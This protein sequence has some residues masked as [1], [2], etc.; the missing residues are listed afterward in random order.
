MFPDQRG[1]ITG[2]A[3]RPGFGAGALI[4]APIATRLD[5]E[6]R[7][8]QTFAILGVAYFVAV[9]GGALSWKPPEGTG[10]RRGQISIFAVRSP[11]A[12][13]EI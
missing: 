3:V 7:L 2:L 13:I 9:T 6:R 12:E 8:L 5:R 4:T 11:D 1:L 10:G